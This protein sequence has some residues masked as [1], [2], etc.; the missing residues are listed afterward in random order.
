M[1]KRVLSSMI[2]TGS[3]VAGASP[4]F[5]QSSVTLYGSADAGLSYIS[6][7]TALGSTSG[8]R[9]AVKMSQSVWNAS[10]FGFV[11]FEDLGGG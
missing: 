3:V 9:S 8:G 11:G 2:L 7:Q 4:A 5:A 1:K 10:K 6:S